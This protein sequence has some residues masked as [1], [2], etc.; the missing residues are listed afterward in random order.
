MLDAGL[1]IG[2][3]AAIFLFIFMLARSMVWFNVPGILTD[4]VTTYVQSKLVFLVIVNILIIFMGMIMNEM[5]CEI[6]AT[7]MLLPIAV[8]G[9]GMNPYHFSAIVLVNAS[10]ANLTPPVAA[11]LYFAAGVGKVPIIIFPPN[12][13]MRTVLTYILF[14]HLPV[15]IL[16]TYIPELSLVLL[17]LWQG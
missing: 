14:G 16:T 12:R 8:A 5:T 2:S 10:L 4:L 13:Y 3:L 17:N 15:L 1:T 9:Y 11:N 6:V 7:I